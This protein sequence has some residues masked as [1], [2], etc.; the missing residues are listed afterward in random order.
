MGKK[1]RCAAFECN[2]DLRFPTKYMVKDYT[3]F[4]RG[5]FLLLQG[6]KALGYLD[7]PTEPEGI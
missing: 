3:S 6:P 2:D 7:E 1:D 4:F 5:T